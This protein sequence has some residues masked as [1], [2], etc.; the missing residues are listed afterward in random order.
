MLPKDM[1]ANPMKLPIALF[2]SFLVMLAASQ[3][4][5]G[6]VYQERSSIE[7]RSAGERG[8]MIV[9][10]HGMPGHGMMR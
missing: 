9:R 2:V 5:E 4:N 6:G 7:E 3:R 10:M 1:K 8:W